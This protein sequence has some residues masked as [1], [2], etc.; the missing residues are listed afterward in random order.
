MS[1]RDP[2]E[3]QL[4]GQPVVVLGGTSGIGL[5][6]ARRARHPGTDVI[7][8]ARDALNRIGP[9]LGASVWPSTSVTR[10]R[11]L[12]GTGQGTQQPVCDLPLYGLV[13][14]MSHQPSVARIIV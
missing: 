14:S 10:P 2:N 4:A 1:G 3:R 13:A 7:L 9:E 11:S 6:T 5:E 8:T 12:I